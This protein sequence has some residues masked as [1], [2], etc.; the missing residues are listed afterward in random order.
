MVNCCSHFWA[1]THAFIVI[2]VLCTSSSCI[3]TYIFTLL[4]IYHVT[5]KL[6][7]RNSSNAVYTV[8]WITCE[9]LQ[10]FTQQWSEVL[11]FKSTIMCVRPFIHSNSLVLIQSHW[12]SHYGLL[13][14]CT[15]QSIEGFMSA[16]SIE[17]C[18]SHRA[19]KGQYYQV[20]LW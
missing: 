6:Q 12:F 18:C 19:V 8:F 3:N 14:W 15:F 7:Q 20:S 2:L 16:V 11:N 10:W 13:W 9:L 5:F 4:L 1:Q 17:T